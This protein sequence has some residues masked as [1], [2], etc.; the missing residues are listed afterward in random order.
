MFV[1][2]VYVYFAKNVANIVSL[3]ILGS[4]F[5]DC[6]VVGGPHRPVHHLILYQEMSFWSSD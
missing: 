2:Y 5:S 3:L 4:I 6:D 1:F